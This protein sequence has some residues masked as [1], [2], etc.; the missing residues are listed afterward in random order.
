MVDIDLR[1]IVTDVGPYCDG[2]VRADQHDGA[3][4]AGLD[5]DI[6]TDTISDFDAD[7]SA[8]QRVVVS[9]TGALIRPLL[10]RLLDF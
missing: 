1:D 6:S 5:H 9:V 7:S 10:S 8:E 2:D 3:T 4:D